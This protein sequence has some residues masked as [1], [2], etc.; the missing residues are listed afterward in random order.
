[1]CILL[2]KSVTRTARPNTKQN[3]AASDFGNNCRRRINRP[4]KLKGH[5]RLHA[6]K[7]DE[8]SKQVSSRKGCALSPTLRQAFCRKL[9][10]YKEKL[11]SPLSALA[12]QKGP[13]ECKVLEL[14][15][16]GGA[17]FE[18]VTAPVE[19]T[20]TEPNVSFAP[21]FKDTVAKAQGGHKINDLVEA[22]K[23]DDNS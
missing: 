3:V 2:V 22:R 20:V 6:G 14:G 5:S 13:H 7:D 12:S 17:N 21:Y 23:R 9:R 19:W 18:F 4:E 10:P 16:G 8:A 1:M 15:G 11:F